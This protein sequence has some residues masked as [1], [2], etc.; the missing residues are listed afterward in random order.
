MTTRPCLP[1][2][3]KQSFYTEIQHVP[4]YLAA[5]AGGLWLP[6]VKCLA[7]GADEWQVPGDAPLRITW[8]QVSA[9]ALL[10]MLTG[11][12]ATCTSLG[13]SK[14]PTCQLQ[15]FAAERHGYQEPAA[16]IWTVA[17]PISI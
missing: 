2:K 3:S 13:T 17:C 7:G 4:G 12:V 1:P 5:A 9:K 16:T 8:E 15:L 6:D 10:L 11:L 14:T